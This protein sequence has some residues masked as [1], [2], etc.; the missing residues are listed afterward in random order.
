MLLK[1]RH[2]MGKA[3]QISFYHI[4]QTSTAKGT[5]DC[6]K[7]I[8]ADNVDTTLHACDFGQNIGRE[9]QHGQV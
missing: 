6:K 3:S 2:C 4:G 9:M 1:R 7:G 8:S 5:I